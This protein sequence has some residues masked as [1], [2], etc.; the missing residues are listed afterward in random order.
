[1]YSFFGPLSVNSSMVAK[2]ESEE[3]FLNIVQAESDEI[4]KIAIKAVKII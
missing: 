3:F 2:E 4:K 1:M